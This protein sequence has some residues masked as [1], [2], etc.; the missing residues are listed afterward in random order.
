MPKAIE[1][2]N[3]S[4]RYHDGTA[5]LRDITLSIEHGQ[6]VALIGPN[7]AGKST[8]LLAMAGFVKGDGKVLV[9]GLEIN[10]K[11]LK[12]IRAIISS[13]MENPDD[14]LFMPTLFDDVAFGPLNMGLEAEQ[15]KVRVADALRTVGLSDMAEKAPHHLSAGQKRAAAIATVLSMAPE[16]ITL[17][18]PDSS[19][20]PRNRNNLI[21]L[22][23]ALPQTLIAA[24]CNM[25]FA[26]ALGDRAV[27]LDKGCIIADG[28]AEKIMSDSKLMA[29]HGLEVPVKLR[30]R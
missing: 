10:K 29:E 4:Y 15:I 20:D 18:E 8:L 25:N 1:L 2:R 3:F 11:N 26:A 7:G 5:A 9:N 22:L 14:Q 24:T 19:L 30:G 27:L 28:D 23:T 13:C 21:K 12:K 17:D 6:R 16:I